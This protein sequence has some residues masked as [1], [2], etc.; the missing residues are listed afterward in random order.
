MA[1]HRW[2]LLLGCLVAAGAATATPPPTASVTAPIR[3]SVETSA[4]AAVA[5]ARVEL[6]PVLDNF[7][8]ARRFLDGDGAAEPVA[9]ATTGADGRYELRAPVP[10]LFRITVRAAGSVPV[11]LAP[12]AV[13]EARSLPPA[14][15]HPDAGGRVEVA[16]AGGGPLAGVWVFAHRAGKPAASGWRPALRLMRTGSDGAADLP[17]LQGERLDVTVFA[18]EQGY[19]EE[20]FEVTGA[21][22]TVPGGTAPRQRFEVRDPRGLPVTRVVAAIGALDWPAAVS[23]ADGRLQ[24]PRIGTAP[25]PVHLL[26]ADGR[27]LRIR[28]DDLAAP[29]FGDPVVLRLPDAGALAGRTLR[30]DDRRPLAGA[31]VWPAADPGAA[32]VSGEDGAFLLAL[33]GQASWLRAEAGGFRPAEDARAAVG[34]SAEILLAVRR[35]GFGQVAD[36]E[37]QPIAGAQVALLSAA[38]MRGREPTIVVAVDDGSFTVPHLPDG[39]L[40]LLARRHG[41]APLEVRG[42][43]PAAGGDLG[44]LILEP[45]AAIRGRVSD[46]RGRAVPG[47]G[48]WLT[49]DLRRPAADLLADE[50]EVPPVAVTSADGGFLVDDLEIGGRFHLVV[51]AEGYLPAAFEAVSAPTVDPLAV[52]LDVGGSVRG[53]VVDEDGRP[54]AG[55]DVN[56]AA[57]LVRPTLELPRLGPEHQYQTLSTA[58]GGFAFDGVAAGRFE[59]A[60]SAEGYRTPPPRE[61]SVTAGGGAG[62]A[63]DADADADEI[64]FVLSSGAVLHGRVATADGEP[65]A[66]ARILSGDAGGISGGDGRY[67]VAGLASGRQTVVARHRYLDEVGAEIVIEDGENRHDFELAS[68]R[69]VSGRVV[70]ENGEP[71]AGA[72]VE[73]DRTGGEGYLHLEAESGDGGAFELA[74]VADGRYAVHAAAAGHAWSEQPRPLV[75][76]G[77]AVEGVEIVLA[78]AAVARGLVRGFELDELA[79]L[80]V[81]AESAGGPERRGRVDYEGRYEIAGLGPGDWLL[82][83]STPDRVR[84]ARARVAIAPGVGEVQRD[85]ELEGF[86]L[87]GQVI[88]DGEPLAGA[89]VSVAGQDVALGRHVVSGHDGAFELEQLPAGS[90]LLSASHPR[91]LLA[92]NGDLTI[93]GDEQVTIELE[94]ARVHGQVAGARGE[95]LAGARVSLRQVQADGSGGSVYGVAA[96]ASGEFAVPQLTAGRYRVGV[97]HDGYEA[98]EDEVELVAGSTARLHYELE[99]TPGLELAVEVAG[100][101][102]P[103]WVAVSATGPDGRVVFVDRRSA[104]PDGRIRFPTVPAG[105]WP[106]VVSAPGAAPKE[107][108]ATVPGEPRAVVLEPASRMRIRVASLAET[109]QV[110]TVRLLDG[111]G[112]AL[113]GLGG[114]G[115]LVDAWRLA[116][117]VAEISGVPPGLWTVRVSQPDGTVRDATVVTAAEPEVLVSLE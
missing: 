33:A 47:A 24:L 70:D 87:T 103:P 71:V 17:R 100:S 91:Q 115:R 79:R 49:A 90:Y 72:L 111:G 69:R 36:G 93:A 30:Q 22:F 99:P 59:I 66:G 60:V 108:T 114:G 82:R 56:L 7:T 20:R 26:A 92:W 3:G 106:I 64:L 98:L 83:A 88:F 102:S 67:R 113:R 10:G 54:V 12:V 48:V 112:R 50:P 4:G 107:L 43:R 18:P 31:L 101:G 96:D 74:M 58:G 16:A 75:V 14:T 105:T 32:V 44:T 65:V 11:E 28:L 9:L 95:P 6:T 25:L 52:A 109:D 68:G 39:R 84:E 80:E 8:R 34:E 41:Y 29:P 116:A 51:R 45:G 62:E 73:L 13:V 27:R 2:T 35:P 85:L 53:R 23:G 21:A 104:G 81:V 94:A 110:A 89:R 15:L 117:G 38:A 46:L 77:A 55:A 19:S 40:D 97:R 42:I 76:A 61:V 57:S 78:P 86:A 1:F 5:G 37:G 63:G